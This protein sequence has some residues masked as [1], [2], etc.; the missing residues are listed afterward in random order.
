VYWHIISSLSQYTPDGNTKFTTF[1]VDTRV[2]DKPVVRVKLYV[3]GE[4]SWKVDV[5]GKPIHLERALLEEEEATG[6][7]AL[8]KGWRELLSFIRRSFFWAA[9]M[10]K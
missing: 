2:F 8:N 9:E 10:E 5:L 4:E 6:L 1:E 7:G 3:D